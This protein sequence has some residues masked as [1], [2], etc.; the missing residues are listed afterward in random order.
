MTNDPTPATDHE[1]R[2]KI[3]EMIK[4]IR[5]ALMVTTDDDG[6]LRSRPM[7]VHQ[8]SYDGHL[9]FFTKVTS[10]KIEQ[11]EGNPDLLLAYSDPDRQ[12]YVSVTGKAEV[13]RDRELIRGMWSEMLRIWFPKGQDDPELALIKVTMQDAEYWDSP[14]SAMVLAFGYLKSRIT[15][16]SPDPGTHGRVRF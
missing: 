7:A 11:I 8:T 6:R 14:S 9:W 1:S 12:N 3:W 4:D 13:I 5:I 2:Q 16:E 15:G 10:S